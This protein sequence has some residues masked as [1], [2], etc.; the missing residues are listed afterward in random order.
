M[1]GEW[2]HLGPFDFGIGVRNL[3]RAVEQAR[4]ISMEVRGE[5]QCLDL[6]DGAIWRYV[7]L[8]P[9]TTSTSACPKRATEQIGRSRVGCIIATHRNEET[10]RWKTKRGPRGWR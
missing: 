4:A 5:P 6:G 1:R 10:L 7:Y 8:A 2:G 3:G 9:R